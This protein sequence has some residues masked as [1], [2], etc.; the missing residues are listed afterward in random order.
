MSGQH[1]DMGEE[2][3]SLGGGSVGGLPWRFQQVE[4]DAR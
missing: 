3:R 2:A 1:E 4:R